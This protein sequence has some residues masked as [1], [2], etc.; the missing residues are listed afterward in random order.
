MKWRRPMRAAPHS[1]R[2]IA[3][4]P[5]LVLLLGSAH[6]ANAKLLATIEV[7]LQGFR[8]EGTACGVGAIFNSAVRSAS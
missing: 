5:L 1:G 2:S 3:T 6:I 8:P 4:V 7:G